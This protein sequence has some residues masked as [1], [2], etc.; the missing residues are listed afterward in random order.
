MNAQVNLRLP[1]NLLRLVRT[2]SEKH[3]FGS[4]QDFIKETIREKL[5]NEPEITR[6]EL[7]LVK[8]LLEVSEKKNLYG[9][10]EELFTKLRRR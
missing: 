3:G 6:E 5:F 8:K 10:E 4:I 9:T 2:Y 7:V 1:Q